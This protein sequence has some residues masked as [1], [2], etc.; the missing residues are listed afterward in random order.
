M[1]ILS[2]S[3]GAAAAPPLASPQKPAKEADAPP[4]SPAPAPKAKDEPPAAPPRHV[5]KCLD[6][7]TDG[8]LTFGRS[9]FPI[10]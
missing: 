9:D 10:Y 2:E 8:V 3:N 7:E 6:E 4:P 1:G 5:P